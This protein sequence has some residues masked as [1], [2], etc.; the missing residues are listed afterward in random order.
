MNLFSFFLLAAALLRLS[1]A[2]PAGSSISPP[3]PP[4]PVHI[5]SQSPDPRRPWI[6]FRDWLI[7]SIWDI[8]KP[9]SQRPLKDSPRDHL[10]SK[11]LARYG[12]D[13]VLRFHLRRKD[14]AEALAQASEILFLDVWTSTPAFVDIRLAQE[15]VCLLSLWVILAHRLD[16][17][18]AGSVARLSS[19]CLYS[20][21]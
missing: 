12:S 4:Q 7:E 1:F 19:N 17:L 13:V 3:P 10:P 16:S 20:H 18:V 9:T 15:V 21:Y 6:R 8:P 5:L 11:V 14:E 2:V